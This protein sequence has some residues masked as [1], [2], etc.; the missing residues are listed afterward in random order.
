[1]SPQPER[2]SAIGK[3]IGRRRMAGNGREAEGP[4]LGKQLTSAVGAPMTWSGRKRSVCFRA[5]DAGKR[6][7][8]FGPVPTFSDIN[9]GHAIVRIWPLMNVRSRHHSVAQLGDPHVPRVSTVGA[10]RS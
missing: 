8:P 10:L 7:D 9:S 2:T 1:M 5:S 3:R 4:V 6:T